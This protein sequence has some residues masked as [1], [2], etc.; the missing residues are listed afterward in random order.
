MAN[1]QGETRGAA[2]AKRERHSIESASKGGWHKQKNAI[3][4]CI[5]TPSERAQKSHTRRGAIK[6]PLSHHLP[7]K[8]YRFR[9]KRLVSRETPR[10]TIQNPQ[11]KHNWK[12][13]SAHFAKRTQRTVKRGVQKARARNRPLVREEPTNAS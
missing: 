13:R 7:F 10:V 4:F 5:S 3:A 1:K 9:Q 8:N 2:Q 12:T 6:R 11:P